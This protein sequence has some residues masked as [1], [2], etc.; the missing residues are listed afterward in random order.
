MTTP[1]AAGFVFMVVVALCAIAWG[2]A[3]DRAF[4]RQEIQIARL[5]TASKR[6]DRRLN[7]LAGSLNV[8]INDPIADD[9]P[10][11][12]AA[13]DDDPQTQPIEAQ[14]ATEPIEAVIDRGH[15]AITSRTYEGYGTF[16]FRDG[17][18]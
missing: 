7:D 10:D 13:Q 5:R 1:V 3:L 16:R 4:S 11:A 12:M 6:L 14:P 8:V 18:K 2:Y 15:R 17:T 9:S